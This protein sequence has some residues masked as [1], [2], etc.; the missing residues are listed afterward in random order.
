MQKIIIIGAG[1][2]GLLLAHYLLSRGNYR[3]EI[4]ERR[5]DFRWVEQSKQR[6]FPVSLQTRGISAI[7]EIPGLEKAIAAQGIWSLGS[8]LHSKGGK[9]HKIKRKT[10]LRLVFLEL[11]SAPRLLQ[12]NDQNEQQIVLLLSVGE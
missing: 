7:R 3:V 10:P 4:Y 2:A 1:P 5:P 6:T 9:T 11:V 8:C 12:L